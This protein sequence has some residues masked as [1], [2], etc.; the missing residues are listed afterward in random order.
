MKKMMMIAVL[1]GGMLMPAQIMA[2]NNNGSKPKVEYRNDK[3]KPQEKFEKKI[4]KRKRRNNFNNRYGN[5]KPNRPNVV[6]INRPAP[7]PRPIPPPPPPVKV[8][9]ENDP[10]SAVASVIGLAALAAIIAN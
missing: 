4:D 10:V 1:I 2:R 5:K 9:Y 7:R 8:V 3:K 6:V